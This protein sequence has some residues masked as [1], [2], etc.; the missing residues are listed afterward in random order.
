MAPRS[1]TIDWETLR[2]KIL[3]RLSEGR[4]RKEVIEEFSRDGSSIT[5]VSQDY[6]FCSID[7]DV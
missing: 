3:R 6:S 5:L 7:T 1:S 4:T 2:P